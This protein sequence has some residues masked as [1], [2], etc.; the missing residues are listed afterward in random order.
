MLCIVVDKDTMLDVDGGTKASAIGMMQDR[1][2][3]SNIK[4]SPWFR[5]EVIINCKLLA[6]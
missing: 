5:W 3:K 4:S 6:Q 2:R 1:E